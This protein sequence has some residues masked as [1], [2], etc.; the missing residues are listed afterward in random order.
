MK[1]SRKIIGIDIKKQPHYPFTFIQADALHPPV[2]IDAFDLIHASPPC[3]YYAN[4]TIIQGDKTNHWDS[5]PPTRAFLKKSIVRPI[6]EREKKLRE[7][8]TSLVLWEELWEELWEDAD[9]DLLERLIHKDSRELKAAL[10]LAAARETARLHGRKLGGRR[11][12]PIRFV[13]YILRDAW[14][15]TQYG[16][17]FWARNLCETVRT[18]ENEYARSTVYQ[19]LKEICEK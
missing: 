11:V 8:C 13:K 18:L 5:I 16:W 4:V 7:I 15:T 12:S 19:A 6:T 3:Q 1:S 14:S 2:D 17:G 10:R 9:L